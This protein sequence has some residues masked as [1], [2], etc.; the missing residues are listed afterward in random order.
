MH[1]LKLCC[2]VVSVPFTYRYLNKILLKFAVMTAK[3]QNSEILER[4]KFPLYSVHFLTSRHLLVSGGGGSAKTGITNAIVRDFLVIFMFYF[5][6]LYDCVFKKSITILYLNIQ[7]LLELSHDGVH[8]C[9]EKILYYETGD[10]V[11]MNFDV[12]SN[13]KYSYLAAGEEGLC[14]LYKLKYQCLKEDSNSE[15]NGIFL[16]CENTKD[17]NNHF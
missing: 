1:V 9:S 11:V 14:R 16:D 17:S 3:Y 15:K 10:D 7:V 6:H 2:K 5:S 4:L 13:K 8:F 12:F